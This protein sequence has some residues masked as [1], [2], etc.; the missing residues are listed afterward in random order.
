MGH[1]ML[2]NPASTHDLNR[3]REPI[4]LTVEAPVPTWLELALRRPPWVVVRHGRVHDGM[5]PVGVRGLTRQQRFAAFLA[6]A[7]I[8]GRLS[9]E[10][11]YWGA[12]EQKRSIR[13][14][15]F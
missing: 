5:M 10:D 4:A 6:S 14:S 3:L 7:E 12:M 8:A 15:V 9:P 2:V 1:L 11:G 13:R